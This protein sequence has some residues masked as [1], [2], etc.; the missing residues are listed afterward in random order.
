[1]IK[2]FRGIFFVAVAISLLTGCGL[3]SP[4]PSPDQDAYLIKRVPDSV[5]MRRGHDGTILVMP[6]ETAPMYDTR[7]MAY[8][9]VPY[10]ISYYSKNRWAETP[11]QMIEPL[12][13]KTLQKT[14]YYHAVVEPPFAGRYD[15]MLTTN[16]T[17]LQQDYTGCSPILRFTL[18]AN[19]IRTIGN[20]IVATKEFTAIVPLYK[21]DPYAGVLAANTA[22]DQVL[23]E[24]AAF[25]LHHS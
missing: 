25:C 1:M 6:P 17:E 24:L 14:R 18:R 12:I 15:Y 7:D 8:S 2:H 21:R 19:L 20:Q 5:P 13:V 4:V 9:C 16:I 3:F 11:S 22:V 10:K 23:R